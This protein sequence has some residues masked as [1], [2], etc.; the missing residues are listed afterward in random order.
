MSLRVSVTPAG[1]GPSAS[2]TG[3]S[4]RRRT[5]YRLLGVASRGLTA[6]VYMVCLDRRSYCVAHRQAFPDTYRLSALI[7][8]GLR[9]P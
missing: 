1:A 9:I 3:V 4:E 7:Q 5:P 2:R 8:L 6:S